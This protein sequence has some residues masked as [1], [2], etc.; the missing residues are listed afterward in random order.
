M[1]SSDREDGTLYPTIF[2]L[3]SVEPVYMTLLVKSRA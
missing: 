1:P 3:W 2:I